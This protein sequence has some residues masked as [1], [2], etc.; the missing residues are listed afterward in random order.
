VSRLARPLLGTVSRAAVFAVGAST[1]ACWT[2]SS[3]ATA[4]TTTGGGGDLSNKG[5]GQQAPGDDLLAPAPATGFAA[6]YGKCTDSATGQPLAG[7]R[8]E[9][10]AGVGAGRKG[11]TC[12]AQGRY[13]VNDLPPGQWNVRFWGPRDAGRMAPPSQLIE[14]QAGDS[15]RIDGAANNQDWS[16]VPMPYGAPPQ[17]RRVV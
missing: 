4:N 13:V 10:I 1:A 16:N 17:R 15:K 14:V 11:T 3:P 7:T 9:L 8:V 5:S 6:I 12:D 2:S